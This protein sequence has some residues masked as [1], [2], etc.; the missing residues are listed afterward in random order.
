MKNHKFTDV[1]E[2]EDNVNYFET[3]VICKHGR[4]SQLIN[5][6]TGEHYHIPFWKFIF[7]F[8]I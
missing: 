5:I 1:L 6:E 4:I 8:F 2:E 7:S 3:L